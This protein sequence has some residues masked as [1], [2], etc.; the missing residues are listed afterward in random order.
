MA[1]RETLHHWTCHCCSTVNGPTIRS[2]ASCS[3]LHYERHANVRASQRAAIDL[4]P[5]GT[6]SIPGRL[7]SP[8]HPKQIAAGVQRVEVESA[9]SGKYSLRH[10]EQI[11][12]VHEATNWD[13]EGG[14][15]T[16]READT[17]PDYLPSK[18]HHKSVEQILSE[19]EAF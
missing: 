8:L 6:I 12:L 10:L 9:L 13:A 18:E 1:R 7:D 17:V 3:Q 5:D 16:V 4:A 2:C 15:M 11:G 14:M 19:P